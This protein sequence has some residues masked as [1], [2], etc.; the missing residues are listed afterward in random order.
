MNKI[1][2]RIGD[3]RNRSVNIE[4]HIEFD[5]ICT[6]KYELLDSAKKQHFRVI[7]KL[8]RM[9]VNIIS[10]DKYSVLFDTENL[11]KLDAIWW[12]KWEVSHKI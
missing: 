2:S 10:E 9:P 12:V 5:P 4:Q 7:H 1:I 6:I 8:T 11:D 3:I